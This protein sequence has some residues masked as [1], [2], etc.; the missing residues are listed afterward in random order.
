MLTPLLLTELLRE[1][2]AA[3]GGRVVNVTGGM[4]RG[5][6]QLD[7]V[8]AERGFVGLP[9]YSHAKLAMRR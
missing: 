6:L 2:L 5:P 9:S 8:Q 4:P 7:N 3:A 1:P